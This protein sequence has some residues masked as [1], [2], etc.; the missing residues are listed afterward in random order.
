[1]YSEKLIACIKV[2]GQILRESGETVTLP[3]NSEYSIYLKNLDS[4][5]IQASISVD[6][7]DATEGTRLIINP[8]SS[9]ELERFTQWRK[10]QRG[11]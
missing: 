5:R 3:F 9:L 2:N 8:N 11:K 4:V 6:G 1:M 7:Q 10:S